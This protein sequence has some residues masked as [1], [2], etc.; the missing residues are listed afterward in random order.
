VNLARIGPNPERPNKPDLVCATGP[1]VTLGVYHQ[2]QVH[3]DTVL[4]QLAK[5]ILPFLHATGQCLVRAQHFDRIDWRRVAH[6]GLFR[7]D[8]LAILE[9]HSDGPALVHENFVHVRI[10]LELAAKLFQPPS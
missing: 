7:L 2:E 10:Q 9:S 1:D 5:W 4:G 8:D 3:D 6:H